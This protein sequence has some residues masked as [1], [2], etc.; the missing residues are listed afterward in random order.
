KNAVRHAADD[1]RTPLQALSRD[2]F[3]HPELSLQEV[4]STRRLQETLKEAGFE[5]TPGVAGL[6]TSFVAVK[7]G[8]RPGARIAFLAEYDALPGIGHACGHNLIAAAGVGAGLALGSIAQN[9]DGEI[10][11]IGTP[12][13]ETVGGKCIMVREGIFQGVDAALMVHPGSEWRVETD[14]LACIS[15]EVIYTGREAHAVAWPERGLNALDAL[16][17][18]FIAVEMLRKR[19]GRDVRIPG[20]ILEGGLRPN[21]VPAR[22]VGHFTL[23]APDSATR[24]AVRREF[25]RTVEGIASGTGCGSAV[26]ATD[27]PYDELHS[28]RAMAAVFRSYLLEM[29]ITPLDGPRPNKGS[30]DMGNVSKAVPALHPFVAICGQEIASH[31]KL[32][33]QASVSPMGEEALMVSVRALALTGLDLLTR[34]DLL[35]SVKSEFLATSR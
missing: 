22:A 34:P 27:E 26:R 24:D 2:L 3:D 29:G 12:A 10:L 21:I 14:S 32:F 33:A 20:V 7:K 4:R 30:L 6:P 23:R 11:V 5:V 17:Q 16:I 19:H 9:L 13:E 18:L 25:E 8:R 31:S 1:L 28:N 35:A 15:L